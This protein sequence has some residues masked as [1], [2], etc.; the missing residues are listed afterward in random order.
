MLKYKF[1]F[2]LKFRKFMTQKQINAFHFNAKSGK[3]KTF[4]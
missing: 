2:A 3:L 1:A 4:V